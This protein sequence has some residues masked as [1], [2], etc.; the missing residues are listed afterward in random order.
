MRFKT[1]AVGSAMGGVRRMLR[2]HLMVV[3]SR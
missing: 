3:K 1:V 2:I